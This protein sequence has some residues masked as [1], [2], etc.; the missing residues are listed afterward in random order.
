M[1]LV[2]GSLGPL[3]FPRLPCHWTPQSCIK[4]VT[5]VRESVCYMLEEKIVKVL[6]VLV[7]LMTGK[8][9]SY[10]TLLF[11]PAY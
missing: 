3:P 6:M 7:V 1:V 4:I 8:Q 9:D 11:F 10:L 5:C 2:E